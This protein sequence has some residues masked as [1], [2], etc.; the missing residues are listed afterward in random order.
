MALVCT[1]RLAGEPKGEFTRTATA[2]A[3]VSAVGD[4]STTSSRRPC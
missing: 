1:E 2:L 3:L 4:S